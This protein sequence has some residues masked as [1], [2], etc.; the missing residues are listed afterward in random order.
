MIIGPI[1]QYASYYN[2][3][4]QR[5]DL[6][7]RYHLLTSH[8]GSSGAAEGIR[9]RNTPANEVPLTWDTPQGK[10]AGGLV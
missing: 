2:Y 7:K 3:I 9:Y 6:N 4:R 10:K 5:Y 8:Q 1:I